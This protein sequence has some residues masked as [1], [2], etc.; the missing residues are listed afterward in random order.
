VEVEDHGAGGDDSDGDS[1][2]GNLPGACPVETELR[3]TEATILKI[4]GNPCGMPLEETAEKIRV[5][6]GK[7]LSCVV[8]MSE[9]CR[10]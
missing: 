5:E 8:K 2:E 7:A 3:S 9:V 6:V 1:V 10:I 4:L